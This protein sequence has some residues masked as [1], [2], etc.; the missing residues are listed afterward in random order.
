MP[1]TWC[2]GAPC[3]PPGADVRTAKYRSQAMLV[4]VR[5]RNFALLLL[6]GLISSVGDLVLSIALPFYVYDLTHSALQTGAMFIA[7]TLPGLLVGSVAGVF[8]D[9]WDR[10]RTMVTADLSR[11]VLMLLLLAVRSR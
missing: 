9:R 11:D 7:S 2:S 8:V 10:K 1:T 6:A 4:V 5:Q 3:P